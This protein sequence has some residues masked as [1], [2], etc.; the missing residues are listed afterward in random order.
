MNLA[1]KLN[2][3]TETSNKR[4]I[5]CT[6]GQM[7][8]SLSDEDAKALNSALASAASTRSIYFALKAEGVVVDRTLLSAHRQGFCR[9]KENS[10]D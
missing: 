7:I 6:V 5:G 1:D 10:Y 2:S 3:I 9:C 8:H 4:A